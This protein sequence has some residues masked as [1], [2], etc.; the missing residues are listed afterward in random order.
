M[1]KL[2]GLSAQTERGRGG[3]VCVKEGFTTAAKG[4]QSA[5][6][7]V[8]AEKELKAAEKRF[9]QKEFRQ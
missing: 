8:Q 9:D 7:G 1:G 3:I 5:K 4:G 2:V 6:A